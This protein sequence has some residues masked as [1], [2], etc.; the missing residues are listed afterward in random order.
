MRGSGFAEAAEE[1]AEVEGPVLGAIGGRLLQAPVQCRVV[2]IEVGEE[3]DVGASMRAGNPCLPV[4][5][6]VPG[7][8]GRGVSVFRARSVPG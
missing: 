7:A 2:Q 8:G 5:D 3:V 1:A 4:K 6:A